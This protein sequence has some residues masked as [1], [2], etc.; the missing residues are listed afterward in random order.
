MRN[1]LI[2]NSLLSEGDRRP[3]KPRADLQSSPCA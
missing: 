1:E 2:V 3:A